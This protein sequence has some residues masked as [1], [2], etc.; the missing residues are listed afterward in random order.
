MNY[1]YLDASITAILLSLSM[2]TGG[3]SLL[4]KG[5]LKKYF[6]IAHGLVSIVAYIA[7]MITYLRAP[8]L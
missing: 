1:H 3:L 6:L 2:I 5:R 7:F 8:T 4:V